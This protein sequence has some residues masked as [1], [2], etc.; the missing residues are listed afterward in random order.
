MAASPLRAV[1]ERERVE[2]QYKERK[3][4]REGGW[5][6][7]AKMNVTFITAVQAMLK[8]MKAN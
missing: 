5:V 1:G 2:I 7:P 8:L 3:R 4:E 6:C